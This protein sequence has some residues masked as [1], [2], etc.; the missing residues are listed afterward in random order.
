MTYKTITAHNEKVLARLVSTEIPTKGKFKDLTG[1][2]FGRY[3]VVGYAGQDKNREIYYWCQCECS[4]PEKLVLAKILRNGKAKSC[5]CYS[6]E[7]HTTHGLWNDPW[8]VIAQDQQQR[9]TN[10]NDKD[11]HN[12]GGRGLKF[13]EGMETIEDRILFYREFFGPAPPEGMEVDRYP[14]NDRGYAKDNVRLAT[15]KENNDNRR[16]SH[17][18]KGTPTYDAWRTMNHCHK[19]EVCERWLDFKNFLEDMG[20]KPEGSRFTRIDKTKPFSKENCYWRISRKQ[21]A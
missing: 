5:G 6:R 9:M 12:Y 20:E 16:D 18:Y 8:Y 19:G 17:G 11:Y 2:V 1:Q 3:T 15:K 13:G 14:D 21:A 4:S 7:I 10:P